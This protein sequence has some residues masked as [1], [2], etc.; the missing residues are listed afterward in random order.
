[1]SLET[2]EKEID[3]DFDYK[4]I[5]GVKLVFERNSYRLENK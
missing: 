3:M 1:M 5:N 4:V 2:T